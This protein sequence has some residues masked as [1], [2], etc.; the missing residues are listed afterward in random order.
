VVL[1]YHEREICPDSQSNR[2]YSIEGDA[3]SRKQLVAGM[4][5]LKPELFKLTA[6]EEAEQKK[7]MAE[8]NAEQEK[9][10][11][12]DQA[13]GKYDVLNNSGIMEKLGSGLIT[14]GEKKG[15]GY[16]VTLDYTKGGGPNWQGVGFYKEI[17][18]D[19]TLWIA[20]GTPKTVGLC[21]YEI[22]GGKLTGKWLPWYIDG[23][24]KT[25]GTEVLSGPA[26]K[27]GALDGDYK[28]ESA[29]APAT[30]ASY[31][32]TVSIHPANIVGSSDNAKPYNI[33]WNI[34]DLKIQGIGVKSG[35]YLLVASGTG[36]DTCI[37][38]YVIGNGS[39]GAD[40]YK[41]GSNEIGRTASSK[42]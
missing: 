15:D 16:P 23:T 3:L 19:K 32:G 31:T 7:A 40:W 28:I 41:L 36:A 14:V 17:Y 26:E 4:L 42:Q 5:I 35:K 2:I 38:W 8:A 39:M 9:L 27:D 21:V 37:A 11:A 30:G 29:A 13:T 18:G 22:D 12:A 33:T 6:A 34:G 1:N 20:Y 10:A 25:T 24:A